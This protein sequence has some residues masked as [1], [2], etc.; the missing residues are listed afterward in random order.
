MQFVTP[1]TPHD[2][3]Y[4]AVFLGLGPVSFGCDNSDCCLAPIDLPLAG[5]G[6][7][8]SLSCRPL[9]LLPCLRTTNRFQSRSGPLMV[10]MKHVIGS[11]KY[12]CN[13]D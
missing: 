9:Y 2:D 7:A 12:V 3:L 11:Q 10:Q 6:F 5:P 8:S 13:L 4:I 1:F